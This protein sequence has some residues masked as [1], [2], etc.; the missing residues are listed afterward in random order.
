MR[1]SV[2]ARTLLLLGVIC[3]VLASAAELYRYVDDRGVVVLDRHDLG[4]IRVPPRASA[5]LLQPL[6]LGIRLSLLLGSDG[7]FITVHRSRECS[8]QRD[9]I[10]IIRSGCI[11]RLPLSTHARTHALKLRSKLVLRF[12]RRRMRQI[13]I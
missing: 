1:K 2:A 6:G 11:R 9:V 13:N 10:R 3:P 8:G 12:R 5:E 7:G 4:R